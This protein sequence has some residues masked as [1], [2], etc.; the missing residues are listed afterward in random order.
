VEAIPTTFVV[1]RDGQ[2]VNR[3]VGYKPAAYFEAIF[4]DLL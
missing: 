1:D 4:E 3:K 2:L